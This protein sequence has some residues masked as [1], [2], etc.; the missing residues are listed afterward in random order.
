MLTRL[1]LLL[2]WVFSIV[3]IA[4]VRTSEVPTPYED[5]DAYEVYS[6]I[7]PSEWPLHAANAKALI[8]Q[9]ETRTYKMC[10]RPDKEWENI[11]GPAISDYQKMNDKHWLLQRKF[12][13]EVPYKLVSSDEL[14]SVFERGSWENFYKEYPASGGVIELSAV[15]FNADKTIAVVYV[16]HLCGILC[17]GGGFQV[18]QKKMGRWVPLDWKGLSCGWES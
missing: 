11:V 3:Q 2:L 1:T 16:A 9:S 4:F 13:I 8:I 15:G 14:K 18:C 6:A 12:S 17:G 10:L 5:A 7:L